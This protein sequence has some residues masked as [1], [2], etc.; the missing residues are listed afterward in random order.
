MDLD[1]VFAGERPGRATDDGPG[2]VAREVDGPRPAEANDGA[3][4]ASRR[5]GKGD[6]GLGVTGQNS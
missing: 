4:T 5:R 6:D 2:Q 1:G 3:Q